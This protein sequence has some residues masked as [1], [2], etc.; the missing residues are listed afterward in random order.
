MQRLAQGLSGLL[1]VVHAILAMIGIIGLIEL[2]IAEPAWPRISNPLFPRWIL[3]IEWPLLLGA[4][5][6]YIFCYVRRVR[7]IGQVMAIAYTAMATLCAV[8]TFAFLTHESRFREMILEYT[9]Y[10]LIL[11][12]LFRSHHMQ[13]PARSR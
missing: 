5:G 12:F 4:G 2:L 8:Q 1:L 11:L 13:E 7:S 3:L 9:T 10:A 6:A